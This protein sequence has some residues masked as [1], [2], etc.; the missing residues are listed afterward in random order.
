M[1]R[2]HQGGAR[3]HT[4]KA[5]G[6]GE[7]GGTLSVYSSQQKSKWRATELSLAAVLGAQL[8]VMATFSHAAAVVW[9]PQIGLYCGG[10]PGLR[11]QV[12]G[13][14]P[15]N[16]VMQVMKNKRQQSYECDDV[17]NVAHVSKRTR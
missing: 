9:L 8:Q 10:W 5:E 1:W 17:I 16:L 3:Q 2:R 4:Y 6:G 14:T 13:C 12:P 11:S 15:L 7:G